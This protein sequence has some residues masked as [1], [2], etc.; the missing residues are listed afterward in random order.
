[1]QIPR[2]PSF[3]KLKLVLP[4]PW[5][6]KVSKNRI[7]CTSLSVAHVTTKDFFSLMMGVMF[8]ILIKG[9]ISIKSAL[10]RGNYRYTGHTH[11]ISLGYTIMFHRD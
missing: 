9:I 10:C 1:M 4:Y 2:I 6:I 8:P 7:N 11:L 3:L 5:A